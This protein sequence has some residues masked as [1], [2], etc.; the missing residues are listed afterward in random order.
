MVIKVDFSCCVEIYN[1]IVLLARAEFRS[2]Q[3]QIFYML[4]KEL[5]RHQIPSASWLEGKP[6][7]PHPTI[8]EKPGSHQDGPIGENTEPA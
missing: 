1:E 7:D 5:S 2:L 3:A 6:L 4:S 8:E